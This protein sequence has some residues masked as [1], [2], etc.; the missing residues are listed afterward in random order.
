MNKDLSWLR[1]LPGRPFIVAEVKMKSP[2]GWVNP[3]MARDQLAICEEV[4]DFISVHTDSMWGGSWDHLVDMRN[5][6]AKPILAKG[7]HPTIAH[8]QRALDCG[9]DHV[10]TVGWHPEG[11]LSQYCWHEVETRDQLIN[12]GARWIVLNSRDPRTGETRTG[13]GV[14]AQRVVT[15]ADSLGHKLVQAS[16]IRCATDVVPGMD[17]ILIGE[18][19]YQ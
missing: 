14:A 18:G 5:R 7:F 3:M 15:S 6:T 16:L 17:A 9:A 12:S 19:L 8:V 11:R 13:T 2:Y 1:Q 4:G 10:L